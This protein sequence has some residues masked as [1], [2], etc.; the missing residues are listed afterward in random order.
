[1]P[2][3]LSTV[4]EIRKRVIS[5]LVDAELQF[6]SRRRTSRR[7][8]IARGLRRRGAKHHPLA[9]RVVSAAVGRTAHRTL[10][11]GLPFLLANWWPIRR[12]PRRH[13]AGQ[14]S[15]VKNDALSRAPADQ[16]ALLLLRVMRAQ[17]PSEATASE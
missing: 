14:P 2:E 15:C 12:R 8:R 17:S 7:V 6:A 13:V 1:M 16:E 3:V 5:D 9:V 11:W 10:V 4:E